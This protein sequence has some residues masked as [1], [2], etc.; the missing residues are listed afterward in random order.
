MTSVKLNNLLSLWKESYDKPRQRIKKQRHHF[1][2]KVPSSQIYGFSKSRV[3]MW[4]LDHEQGW[5][6]KNW[7]FQTVVME[8][9][10]ESPLDCKIKPVHPKGNQS[11]IFIG[12]TD[13]KAETPVLW[14]PDGK[15]WH[16]GKDLDAGKDWRREEKGMTED[17]MVGCHCWL[18]AHEFKQTSRDS[19]GQGSPVCYSPG[20]CKKLDTI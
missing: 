5:S 11:W 1:A 10:L 4:E 2:N 14:P 8:K 15:I 6:S 17:E 20:G 12:R 16:S 19:E 7:C 18:N 3:W 13:A 9:A